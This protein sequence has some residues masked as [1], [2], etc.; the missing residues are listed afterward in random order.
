MLIM[1]IQTALLSEQRSIEC[2]VNSGSLVTL[3]WSIKYCP[4]G[5]PWF[6]DPLY[7]GDYP[8]VMR[9]RLGDRL[10]RFSEDD[11]ELLQNSID[12]V[13]LNHYT[14]RFIAHS[15]NNYSAENFEQNDFSEAQEMER[16]AE[17]EG[18]KAASPWLYIVPWGI[19]KVLKYIA[20]KYNCPPI[21]I[22]ENGMDDEEDDRAPLDEM[23]DDKKRVSY[24]RGY[25]AAVAAAIK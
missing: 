5:H 12:F 18:N 20:E 8:D 17:W 24:F 13:G 1:A 15:T 16:I 7:Y 10:P 21:Y 9:E 14:S 2:R 25:L 22:T 19:Q 6:L 23:L 4:H 11:R 3:F